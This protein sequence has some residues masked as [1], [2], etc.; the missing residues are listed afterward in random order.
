[1]QGLVSKSEG[2]AGRGV[3]GKASQRRRADTR[4]SA[5]QRKGIAKKHFDTICNGCAVYAMYGK[6][7]DM[8]RSAEAKQSIFERKEI[9]Q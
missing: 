5:M 1:M 3:G 7:I 4:R 6:G 8:Q 2:K 9:L